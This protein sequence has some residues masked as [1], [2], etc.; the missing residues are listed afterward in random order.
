M[1][2]KFYKYLTLTIYPISYILWVRKIQ[3]TWVSHQSHR[4]TTILDCCIRSCCT[5]LTKDTSLRHSY[6]QR[7]RVPIRM[8][9]SGPG[10]R[11]ICRVR[12]DFDI[13]LKSITPS[14]GSH[15]L[16]PPCL[17]QLRTVLQ[18]RRSA[19]GAAGHYW[20]S[21]WFDTVPMEPSISHQRLHHEQQKRIP[22][23]Y[24]EP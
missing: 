7:L 8:S 22:M 13:N 3:D 9:H 4:S 15:A 2:L 16:V 5:Q 20:F 24:D 18:R 11:R 23:L 19:V 21:R 1:I 12:D 17:I 6:P 10:S 14:D